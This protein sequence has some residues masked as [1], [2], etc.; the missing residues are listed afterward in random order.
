MK[1][2]QY[3][4]LAVLAS[5]ALVAPA[6][7]AQ[8]TPTPSPAPSIELR[9]GRG[10][11]MNWGKMMGMRS[12][13]IGTVT[14]ISG[15]TLTVTANKVGWGK[16]GKD[17]ST[18]KT[19]PTAIAYTIDA[20]K[21]SVIKAGIASNVA[22]I[23][24]GD[25]VMVQGTITGTNVVATTIRDGVIKPTPKPEPTPLILGNGQPIIAGTISAISGTTLTV[26]N[27]SNVTYTVDASNAKV[28]NK[29]ALS[30]LSTVAVGDNVVVQG[31][32]TGT[33]VTAYSVIDQGATPT[34]QTNDK[35]VT[36]GNIF[37]GIGKFFQ[38]LFGF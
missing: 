22:G 2:K 35:S 4:S 23:A 8:T 33:S 12:G 17:Q 5:L 9:D 27:K 13:V 10:G 31:T 30:T 32:V 26:T 11:M 25:M 28:Q 38:H 16:D 6:V 34:A 37:G 18:P 36:H 7:F 19:T 15:T 3:I 24:V 21:A 1:N 14:S 20:S 29:G